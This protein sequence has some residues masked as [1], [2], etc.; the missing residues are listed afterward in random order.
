MT[1]FHRIW[2]AMLMVAAGSVAAQ[3][4]GRQSY[5]V[6]LA[7]DPVAS[8]AGK[9]SGY[10]ATKPAPGQKINSRSGNVQAYLRYLNGRQASVLASLGNVPVS[11][12][13]G[14]AFNGFTARLTDTEVAKLKGNSDV[15]AI[16]PDQPRSPDTSRTP[17]FLGL[18]GPGGLYGNNITGENVIIGLVDTG[19]TP[20]HP[21]FSD[22]VDGSG[23]PVP[24]QQAGTLVYQ[25]LPAGQWTGTCAQGPGFTATDCNNKLIGAR[26]FHAGFDQS[27]RTRQSVEFTSPRDSD[28]HG[29]HT[30][31]TAGGNS[32]VAASFNG[33]SLGTIS[34]IAPRA[35][36]AA[37]KVCWLY[38]GSATATCF[39]S[40][41]VAAIDA[42][43]SDGVDVINF[44]I[45]G[46]LT[47]YLDPVEVA[48]FNAAAAGVFVAASAG[49]DGPANQVSHMSPW[50]TTV[51]A[52]THDRQLQATA[53]LGN[54]SNYT[55]ASLQ[56]SGLLARPLV[57][58]DNVGM[59]PFANLSPTDQTALRL[60][61]NATDR[62]EFGGSALAALDPTKVAGKIVVCD[63]GNN[64]RV[65]K[66]QAV[67]A[68]GGAG[69]ILLNTSPNTLIE[70][71]HF[72][73]SIHLSD[74]DRSAVRT[75]AAGAVASAAF[76]PAAQVAGVVAPVMADFSSRGPSLADINIL[77][78][79]ITAPGVAI[80]AA[81]APDHALAAS[82]LAGNYPAPAFNFLQGTSMS[83]PHIAGIAA[84][85]RQAK[86]SWSPA[87]IKSALMTT[88]TGVKLANGAPDTDRFGYGAGHANPNSAAAASLVYDAGAPDYLAF[89]C[90]IGLLN[91][92]GATCTTFG[93]IAPWNL[94]LPSL[95]SEVV[96]KQ[97]IQRTV[98]NTG[99]ASTFNAS[100]SIPGYTATVTPSV[101]TLASG[102]KGTFTVTALRT[103]APIGSWVFGNLDWTDGSQTIR[104]P[105]TF[106]AQYLTAPSL[107]QDTRVRA[108]KMFSVVTGFSGTLRANTVGLVP[109]T[110]VAGVVS[111][112]AQSC[113]NVLVPAGTQRLRVALFDSET[114]GLGQDDLDLYVFRNGTLIGR[115]ESGSSNELI[116]IMTP[117]AAQYTL[118]VSIFA[119]SRAGATSSNFTLSSW[120]VAATNGI[121]NSLRVST[122]SNVTIGGVSTVAFLWSVPAGQRYL[123][124]VQY[125]DGVGTQVGQT[126]LYIDNQSTVLVAPASSSKTMRKAQ[127]L[128]LR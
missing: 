32:G 86:P 15:V 64:A 115:S 24:S 102:A 33:Q 128:S 29:S 96:G 93:S 127:A 107:I 61:Y 49:N 7:D 35:R 65:N 28:G 21:S 123:S 17:A 45:S 75:Y 80:L 48:F 92:T 38:N 120:V 73:P 34:G 70:D 72:V 8:Y 14:V 46:A 91:P 50:L 99:P 6:Q 5:I 1:K 95:T 23:K 59:L 94:N 41:S 126:A 104:S 44:S 71:T 63:R 116:E 27:G 111:M 58:S 74:T 113:S 78:P 79:D 87:A 12:R 62:T 100:A 125:T 67:M 97:T 114:T 121:A 57:L 66:S 19:I 9:V 90:G 39:P 30:A 42:A 2:A 81:V 106:K 18:S 103:T 77:K 16:T 52:S 56:S 53:T 68:A 89:L 37:Y 112:N 40:D 76:S 60:C 43:V 4:A 69:M 110:R 36:I 88:A 85:L 105:V 117:A 118:C 98:T 25:A 51:A 55:G 124:T 10:A 83:S 108:N 3:Q 122:P 54:A 22:K 47:N 20:E 13:Y 109:A 31:S 84:L 119:T 82:I 26:F 11:H 101:L